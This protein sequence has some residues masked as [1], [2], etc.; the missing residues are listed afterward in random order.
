MLEH[1][2]NVA[3]YPTSEGYH[4]ASVTTNTRLLWLFVL[5]FAFDFRGEKG[6]GFMQMGMAALNAATFLVLA[7]SYRTALPRRGISALVFWPWILLLFVGSIG[8]FVDDV[9]FKNYIRIIYPFWLFLEGF[10]VVWW[11][12]KNENNLHTIVKSM[13]LSSILSVIFTLIFGFVFSGLSVTQIR[14]QILSPL[15]PFLLVVSIFDLFFLKRKRIWSGFV[16]LSLLAIIALSVTRGMI[17]VVGLVFGVLFIAWIFT[18]LSSVANVP[19]PIYRL[20]V[21]GTLLLVLGVGLLALTSPD[22][23]LRWMHRSSGSVSD[24]TFWTRVAA[25]VGQYDKV[26]SINL[27]WLFGAGFGSTYPWPVWEF[28]WVIPFLG[29]DI[30]WVASSP[31]EFMWMTFLYYGGYIVGGVVIGV[32]LITLLRGFRELVELV[33]QRTWRS[34]AVR[35]YWVGILG[36]FAF[37]GLSFTANPFIIRLSA[38]YMGLCLGLVVLSRISCCRPVSNA[39]RYLEKPSHFGCI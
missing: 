6:A 31:G 20:V 5:S 19:K 11:A 24:V 14:Y 2:R 9:P 18:G 29:P 13:T 33:R 28:P 25:V 15:I 34:Y 22:V 8:A 4:C 26:G 1:I 23:L 32:L 10:L 7:A 38:F 37:M 35:P 36:Y 39:S 30:H 21:T 12:G 16:I 17:I 3:D 27:G